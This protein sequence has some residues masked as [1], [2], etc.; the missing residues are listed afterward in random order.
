MSFTVLSQC[1][2]VKAQTGEF[3]DYDP[4]EIKSNGTKGLEILLS[5]SMS[6]FFK[7]SDLAYD[8]ETQH[9]SFLGFRGDGICCSTESDASYVHLMDNKMSWNSV[10]PVPSPVPIK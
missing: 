5:L 7:C 2:V 8:I 4:F 3:R 1:V 10:I 9:P 6:K